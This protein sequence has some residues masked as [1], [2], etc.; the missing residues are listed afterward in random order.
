LA[1]IIVSTVPPVDVNTWRYYIERTDSD[2]SGSKTVHTATMDREYYERMSNQVVLPEEFVKRSINFLLKKEGKDS[3][4]K[5]FNI[6]QISVLP[7]IIMT[8]VITFRAYPKIIL[9]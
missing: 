2:G 5:E 4:L 7:I 1:R 8:E 9:L 6:R 3:I